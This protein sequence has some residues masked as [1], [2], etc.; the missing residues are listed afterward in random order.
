MWA[1][2]SNPAISASFDQEAAAVLMARISTFKAEVDDAP[3]VLRWLDRMLIRMVNHPNQCQRFANY[4]KDDMNSFQLAPN[5]S[6]YPQFMFHL[7]RSPFLQVFNNSP[8]E[9]TYTRHIINREDTN[10]SLIMIQPT[11]TQYS[12]EAE[13]QPV[14]LDS[15]SMQPNVILVMD[16]FFHVLIWHGETI[17][18][19]RREKY[20]E[21]P[22]YAA[23]K[24]MLEAPKADAQEILKERIPLP[25]Y[26]DC[27]HGG[28]Q[29]RFLLAKVNPSSP[30]QGAGGGH[31]FPTDDVSLQVFM[32]HLKKL[33]V[34]TS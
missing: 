17:V 27:D 33:S 29:A 12:M 24:N 15:Q 3:D 6:I 13:P 14:L 23:F 21:N 7:R 16:T 11:L 28:S 30:M 32:E 34:A 10:N 8:D 5:F 1:E 22:T 31:V 9:T 20:H 19:W 25:R 2:P 18:A 26:I 4:V